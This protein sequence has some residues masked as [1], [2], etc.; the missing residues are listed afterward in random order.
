[1]LCPAMLRAQAPAKTAGRYVLP[2]T[3]TP[4]NNMALPTIL[5]GSDT[6]RLMFHTAFSSVTLTEEGARKAGTVQFTRTDT[7]SSW[8]GSGNTSRYSGGNRVQMGACV[9]ENISIW[10]D[11]NSGPGTDGKFGPDLF[12]GRVLEIDFGKKRLTVSNKLPAK[13]RRYQK[14]KLHA[15]GDLLFVD[16]SCEVNGQTFPQRFLLHSGYSGGLLLDDAF[17]S[18]HHLSEKLHITDTQ[19]LKDSYGGIVK[20]QKAVLPAFRIGNSRLSDVPA[21]F[22]E[23]NLGRQKMSVLGG[24]ILKRFDWILDAKR[25]YVYVRMHKA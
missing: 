25:E 22:F 19:E 12:E 9:R 2:F 10:E 3:L 15:Q 23:G 18:E 20:V 14:L 4:H 5:N 11:K 24:E 6:L 8:S 16:A 1:M 7:V 13:A 21:G 17:A